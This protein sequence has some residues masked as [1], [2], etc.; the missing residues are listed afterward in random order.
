MSHYRKIDVR[1]WN[2]AKF[3]ALSDDAKMTFLLLLTHPYQTMLGA[4]R[5]SCA[6]LADDLGWPSERLSKAF[7]EV[8]AKDLIRHD[9]ASRLVWLPNFLKYNRPESPNVVKAWVK[10]YELLPECE[11]KAAV[12]AGSEA[13]VKGMSKAFVKA[14]ESL[15][16]D[17]AESG[18]GTGA[19]TGLKAGGAQDAPAPFPAKLKPQALSNTPVPVVPVAPLKPAP[20][21]AGLSES[22][23]EPVQCARGMFEHLAIAAPAKTLHLAADA[24]RILAGQLAMTPYRA[25]LVIQR[26]AELAA[27]A[28]ETV[29]AFWFEDSKWKG[30]MQSPASVGMYRPEAH[31]PEPE[32]VP[33][34]PEGADAELATRIWQGMSKALKGELPTQSF[35]TWIRPI[36]P[37]GALNGELYLQIPSHDFDHVSDRYDI[38]RF[39]PAGVAEIRLLS[40]T[41]AA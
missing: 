29:N 17:Y 37:I 32:P 28:G 27:A 40:A 4:M 19:G 36:K 9:E 16:K 11:L 18:A 25:M 24:I 5:T 15:S 13:F 31:E 6:A 23:L 33:L 3:M 35:D 14:F 10:A 1:I 7:R 39:L 2:D 26:R 34:A 22:E 12:W 8:S 41:E 38:A 21:S 30:Q 20:T